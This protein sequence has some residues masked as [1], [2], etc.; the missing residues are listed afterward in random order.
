MRQLFSIEVGGDVVL[1]DET[2]LLIPQL[3]EVYEKRGSEYIRFIVLVCDYYSPYRQLTEARRREEVAEDIW[4]CS[5]RKV[6]HLDSPEIVESIIKYKKLQYDPVIEQYLVY[7]EKIS[8]YNSYLRKMPI[9]TS[10]SESLQ[11]IMIGL[12][13]ITEARE[14]LK[15]LILK[16]EDD[17]KMRGGGEASLLEELMEN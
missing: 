8:E 1:Q 10:N 16:K 2:F 14:N 17:D 15:D 13:K 4:G 9:N 3:R 7:T 11:K 5:L 6:K 12:E